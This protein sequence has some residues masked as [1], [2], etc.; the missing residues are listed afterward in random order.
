MATG[1]ARISRSKTAK[2]ASGVTSRGE[3][4]VPPVVMMRL[5]WRPSAAVVSSVWIWGISSGTMAV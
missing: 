3:S 4:P 2:V 1:M 5:M